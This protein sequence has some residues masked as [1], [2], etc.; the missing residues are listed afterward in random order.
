MGSE[1]PEGERDWEELI[2][3]DFDI[4]Y[5]PEEGSIP[6]LSFCWCLQEKAN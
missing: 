6:L 5:G 4:S 3:H 1:Y 2:K